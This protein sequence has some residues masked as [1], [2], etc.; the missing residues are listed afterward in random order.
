MKK[1]YQIFTITFLTLIFFLPTVLVSQ[2]ANRHEGKDK[3]VYQWYL[4][5]N[6]GIAQAYGDILAGSWHGA[7]LGG[8]KM[9]CRFIREMTVVARLRHTGVIKTYIAPIMRVMTIVAGVG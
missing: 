5:I 3:L 7:M 6:G 2:N 9:A 4:N 1:N 8:D